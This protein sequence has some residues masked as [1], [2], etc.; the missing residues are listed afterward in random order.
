[1][2]DFT[3]DDRSALRNAANLHHCVNLFLEKA[4]DA[5]LKLAIFGGV[6]EWVDAAVD[7]R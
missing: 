2:I 7:E 3:N 5:R 6:D 4:S 1:M